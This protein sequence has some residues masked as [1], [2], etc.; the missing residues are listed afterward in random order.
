KQ[1]VRLALEWDERV[2]FV[3][4][5]DLSIKRLG[6]MDII[7]EEAAEVSAEDDSARFDADFAIMSLELGRFI[8]RLLEQFGG[9]ERE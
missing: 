8:P 7:Q 6:F 3:L 2:S 9:L 5:E 1:V 4:S